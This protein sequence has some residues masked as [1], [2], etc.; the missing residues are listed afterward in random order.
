MHRFWTGGYFNL[1][2]PVQVV[3]RT[4]VPRRSDDDYNFPIFTAK[5]PV[6]P[7]VRSAPVP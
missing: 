3:P 5:L 6:A 4:F 2:T 7:R 1:P